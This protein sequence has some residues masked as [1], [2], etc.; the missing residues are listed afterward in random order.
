[1]VITFSAADERETEQPTE[2]TET[3]EEIKQVW[4][5]EKEEGIDKKFSPEVEM[6]HI[7]IVIVFTCSLILNV[8]YYIKQ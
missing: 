3:E 7:F 2:H 5:V 4:I 1:M 6:W 8:I